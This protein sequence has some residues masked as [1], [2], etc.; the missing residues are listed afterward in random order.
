LG[1]PRSKYFVARYGSGNKTH[2]ARNAETAA[3][4]DARVLVITD[5]EKSSATIDKD[6]S[7]IL[8]DES[9]GAVAAMRKLTSHPETDKLD[10]ILVTGSSVIVDDDLLPLFNRRATAWFEERGLTAVFEA[11]ADGGFFRIDGSGRDWNTR[12]YVAMITALFEEGTT[13]CLVGTRGLLGE[14]WDS[15]KADTLI[16]LTTAATEMTVNQL[17]GRVIR[18]DPGNP[19]KTADIWDVVCLAPEF[20]KGLDDYLRF[21]R[22]HAKYYGVC[23]DGEIERG[24]GHIHPAL[25]AAGPED[26]A[27]NAGAF[28][29]EMLERAARRGDARSLWKI[30]EPYENIETSA[31]ELKLPEEIF[32]HKAL[33]G[34]L[35]KATALEMGGAERLQGICRA[36]F[37]AMLELGLIRDAGAELAVSERS[38]NYYRIILDSSSSD[39]MSSFAKAVNEIFDPVE[40]QRYIIPRYEESIEHNWFSKLLPEIVGKYFKSR[41]R[42]IATYH[43]LP[44]ILSDAKR[45]AEIF[46]DKWNLY[47][48]PGRA[49]F[50][51]RG[52]GEDALAEAK[53]SGL[54]VE[55]ARA[56]IKSVWK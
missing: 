18:L 2:P 31:L 54:A 33:V 6:L 10:P 52:K 39:D 21:A 41:R 44:A 5:F 35:K 8:T 26:V 46:S 12:N 51:K 45:K 32:R 36:V 3:T 11:V 27:L 34:N 14:G 4:P 47:V 19:A 24:L 37:E 55:N 13:R 28:N 25:T 22:K 23:D 17:R 15:L 50:A 9:G 20:E 7:E 30:G 48:S 16:D 42:G 49:V 38:D 43:P 40:N 29:E 1:I 53:R 56:K